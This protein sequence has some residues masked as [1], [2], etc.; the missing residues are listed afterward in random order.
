MG[1]VKIEAPKAPRGV[2]CG[3]WGGGVHLFTGEG[4]GRGLCPVFLQK[5]FAF[6]ALKSHVCDAL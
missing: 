4:S 2:G 5:N 1:G 3:P 6:F